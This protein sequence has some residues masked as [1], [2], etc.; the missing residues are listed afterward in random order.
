MTFKWGKDEFFLVASATTKHGASCFVA[1]RVRC[2]YGTLKLKGLECEVLSYVEWMDRRGQ[3][4]RLFEP[5]VLLVQLRSLSCQVDS[6][7]PSQGPERQ[8]PGCCRD[9]SLLRIHVLRFS[10]GKA[11]IPAQLRHPKL[12]RDPKQNAK[13]ELRFA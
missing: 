4:C 12:P 8:E 9:P 3:N 6:R 10:S 11:V 13:V 5:F 1:S 7:N 2:R